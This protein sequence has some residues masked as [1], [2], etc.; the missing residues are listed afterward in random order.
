MRMFKT[1]EEFEAFRNKIIKMHDEEGLSL[2][3]I[4][5]KLGI[6]SA[7]ITQIY[8]NVNSK[9]E[10]PY[11]WERAV[12]FDNKTVGL[13]TRRYSR[14]FESIEDDF[15]RWAKKQGYKVYKNGYPDRV[16]EKDGEYIFVEVKNRGEKLTEDQKVMHNIL[17]NCGLKVIVARPSDINFETRE[18]E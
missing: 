12:I 6:S 4:A 8:K 14:E 18:E 11:N 1:K 9:G 5:K 3:K 2:P 15:D 7:K 10:H 13:N 17:R 16:I